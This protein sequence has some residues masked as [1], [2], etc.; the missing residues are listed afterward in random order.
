QHVAHA[1]VA[2]TAHRHHVQQPQAGL[3]LAEVV[4][5]L[6]AEDLV[7]GAHGEDDGAV[8]HRPVQSAV[9]AQPLRREPLRPV[10]AAADQVDVAGG[11]DRLVA[12]HVEPGHVEPALPRPALHHEHVALVAVG[13]EEVG[14]D[15]DGPQNVVA[16]EVTVLVRTSCVGVPGRQLPTRR[17]RSWRPV[18]LAMASTRPGGDCCTAWSRYSH[19]WNC[20]L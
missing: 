7:T 10:L 20:W 4:D 17:R 15:A 8:L 11:G 3:P 18:W 12:A 2:L 13:A 6:V 5:E 14:V 16:D 19:T 1:A 9:P